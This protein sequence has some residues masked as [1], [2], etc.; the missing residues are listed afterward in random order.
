MNL[1]STLRVR[2]RRVALVAVTA[3]SVV[4]LG[5][6]V[7]AAAP[8]PTPK[9]TAHHTTKQGPLGTLTAVP[10]AGARTSDVAIP[11]TCA[12]IVH[13][14]V[15][16]NLD[17]YIYRGERFT[18]VPLGTLSFDGVV[19]TP[20][21]LAL[22]VQTEEFDVF[23]AIL[24]DG[25]LWRVTGDNSGLHSEQLSARGWGGVRHITASPTGTRLYALT[26]DGGLY[27]Y[28]IT[29]AL[30]IKSMG[31]LATS[32]WGAVKFLSP[33]PADNTYD[34][35]VG[36][37]ST[38]GGVNEYLTDRAAGTVSSTRL[39]ASGWGTMRHLSV[40]SCSDSLAVPIIGFNSSNNAYAYYDTNVFNSS[41][42]D[43]RSAGQVGSGFS[44]LL[45]D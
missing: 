22:A 15:N 20:K 6:S 32:G 38:T 33:L 10:S 1:A 28:A 14:T 9:A 42:A 8:S 2:T 13:R 44:G 40:G 23:F 29:S 31:A 25:S 11:T 34:A 37:I 5:A 27:R 17:R 19:Q 43:W 41:G 18:R 7:A 21:T 24:N 45:S 30:G 4:T 39:F 26:N 3:A 12:G 36:V 16:G 35:F